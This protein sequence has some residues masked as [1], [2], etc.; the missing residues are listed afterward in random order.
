MVGGG[1]GGGGHLLHLVARAGASL[2]A[3]ATHARAGL[4]PVPL[5]ALQHVR[6]IR[7]ER[8]CMTYALYSH[9]QLAR[10]HAMRQ[11]RLASNITSSLDECCLW[12]DQLLAMCVWSP[13]SAL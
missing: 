4:L 8:K 11:Q 1:G 6:S 2:L 3:V 12:P 9:T 13:G 5:L 7:S 10:H